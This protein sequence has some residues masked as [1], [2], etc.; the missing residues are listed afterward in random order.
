MWFVSGVL[1]GAQ[2]VK[3]PAPGVGGAAADAAF[4]VEG[5]GGAGFEEAFEPVF[6]DVPLPAAI[7]AGCRVLPV[8]EDFLNLMCPRSL[9]HV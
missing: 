9:S 4:E 1:I 6:V 5:A 2:C 8:A 3:K 7:P